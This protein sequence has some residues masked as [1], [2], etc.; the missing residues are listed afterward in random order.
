MPYAAPYV[1]VQDFR[2]LGV[3][4]PPDDAAID[5]AIA[6][7]QEL[8]ER[9]TR[10]FFGPVTLEFSFDG[11]E[12]DT[13]HFAVPIISVEWLR[14]N[15]STTN[16]DPSLYMVYNGRTPPNDHRKNPRVAL[17][18]GPARDIFTAPLSLGQLKFHKGRQN[19][20]IRGVFGYT[21]TGDLTPQPIINATIRMVIQLLGNPP[22]GAAP[23][24]PPTTIAGVV[25]EEWTDGHKYKIANTTK[26]TAPFLDGLTQDPFVRDV[27]KMYRG[28]I[29]VA[30]PAHW[31][32]V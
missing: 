24:A 10:Q 26:E 6:L 23:I 15:G 20:R 5:A 28:P 31:G 1:T 30:T 8:L 13:I 25:I 16:L 21:E 11:E 32:V 17:V 12:A 19:H 14:I 29:G 4:N 22:Y 9:A 18:R 2:D 7:A 3:P 27:I